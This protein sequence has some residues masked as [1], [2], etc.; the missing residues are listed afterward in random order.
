MTYLSHCW[1]MVAW[2][3]DV[4]STPT[5]LTLLNE[6]VVLY[7]TEDGAVVVMED[8]C[9]H[10]LAPCPS[11]MWRVPIFAAHIMVSNSPA[12]GDAW[13]FPVRARYLACCA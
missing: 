2:S 4:N 3:R 1:Y 13:R 5:P 11:D 9:P 8:R 10:K 6:P 7:R 12:M